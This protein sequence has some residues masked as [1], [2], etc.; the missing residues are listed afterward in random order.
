[1]TQVIAQGGGFYGLAFFTTPKSVDE[2]RQAMARAGLRMTPS[3]VGVD[4]ATDTMAI[5]EKA[6]PDLV[7]QPIPVVLFDTGHSDKDLD[8]LNKIKSELR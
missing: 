1:M 4:D 3:S 8:W 7:P 2:V 6:H 5:A